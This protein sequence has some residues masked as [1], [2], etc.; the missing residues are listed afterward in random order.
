[1]KVFTRHCFNL[2]SWNQIVVSV[3]DLKMWLPLSDKINTSEVV[4]WEKF[5]NAT[6]SF[7]P[8]RPMV[9]FSSALN[10]TYPSWLNNPAKSYSLRKSSITIFFIMK[11]WW[12]MESDWFMFQLSKSTSINLSQAS[13]IIF[14]P[15]LKHKVPLIPTVIYLSRS[16]AV[17]FWGDF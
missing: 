17:V 7:L 13:C 1:M 12:L 11:W 8:T 14:L 16:L 5:H 6:Y 9:S 15:S 4:D 2:L 3:R 10:I